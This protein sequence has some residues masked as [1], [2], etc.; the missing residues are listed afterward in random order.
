MTTITPIQDFYTLET[1][2]ASAVATSGTFTSGWPTGAQI[3]RFAMGKN[4][5]AVIDGKEYIAPRDFTVAFTSSSVLTYTWLG[6]NTLRAGSRVFIQLDVGGANPVPEVNR[7]HY[8]RVAVV[9]LGA[10]IVADV[11]GISVIELKG[12]AGDM[13][14]GGAAASGGV[15][16]LDVPRN[17]TLTVAT[18]NQSG[19]SFTVYGT[20]EYG[21]AVVET[22]TGPNANTVAG[23]KAFKTVTRVAASAAIATNGVSVGFGDVLGLPIHLR[24]VDQIVSQFEGNTKPTA[25]TAV[26][27][28]SPLTKSTAT[29]ADVRG[30]YDPNSACD[31]AKAF[32]LFIVTDDPTFLGNP[33]YAG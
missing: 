1:R 9:N 19:V 6:T 29:T 14:I 2:L 4:H 28:L 15:A 18:T 13:T 8:G 3:G 25:G 20:D 30:T 23:V 32:T 33:Q 5:K 31:G 21:E 10:P 11:D 24:N 17:V 26:A 22:I 16:T 12:A 7:T 27:G